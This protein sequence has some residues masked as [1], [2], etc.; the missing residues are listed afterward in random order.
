MSGRH[1]ARKRARKHHC[2]Q[3][4]SF[5][6]IKKIKKGEGRKEGRTDRRTERRG[7]SLSLSLSTC[8]CLRILFCFCFFFVFFF[9]FFFLVR[10]VCESRLCLIIFWSLPG[11]TARRIF[12]GETPPLIRAEMTPCSI[13]SI[14]CSCQQVPAPK[15]RKKK[16]RKENDRIR[17][18][19]FTNEKRNGKRGIKKK[20]KK[21]F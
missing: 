19:N 14:S 13:L 9:V 11:T 5:F 12:L 16:E 8:E 10:F 2:V 4:I 6:L 15:Q 17:N 21:F 3:Q 18:E 20:G 7:V 1:G